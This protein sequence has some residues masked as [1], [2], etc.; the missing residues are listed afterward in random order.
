MGE[1]TTLSPQIIRMVTDAAASKAPIAKVA[2]KVSGIF[3]P[4]V[5]IIAA[6]TIHL[7]AGGREFRLCSGQ[8]HFGSGYQLP[9]RAGTCCYAGGHHGGQRSRGE[10]GDSLQECH[11]PGGS[12]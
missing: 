12:G 4:A 8:R 6:A 11:S 5:L 10:E 3:V 9:L 1:D 7:D 2:D